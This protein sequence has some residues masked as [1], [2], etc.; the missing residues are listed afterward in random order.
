MQNKEPRSILKDESTFNKFCVKED[1]VFGCKKTYGCSIACPLHRAMLVE[2]L[3]NAK[4]MTLGEAH[5]ACIRQDLGGEDVREC[6]KAMIDSGEKNVSIHTLWD[7]V[8]KKYVKSDSK[9]D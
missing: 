3:M 4:G 9:K 5:K 6:L 7:I 2:Y 8:E 1:K